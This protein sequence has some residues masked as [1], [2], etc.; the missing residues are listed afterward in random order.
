MLP[1]RV[2]DLPRARARFGERAA[3]LTSFLDRVDPLADAAVEVIDALPPGE[4]W[5]VVQQ[6]GAHGIASAP[7]APEAIRA[8]FAQ[9]EEIPVWADWKTIDRG[10]ELL[11]RAGPLGGI[12]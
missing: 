11:L 3:R 7:R 8:L 2:V 10:G 1:A 6:A 4:G 5:R 12:V 9:I